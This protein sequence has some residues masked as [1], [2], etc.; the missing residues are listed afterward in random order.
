MMNEA[1]NSHTTQE[2]QGNGSKAKPAAKKASKKKEQDKKPDEMKYV[3]YFY[4]PQIVNKLWKQDLQEG[5]VESEVRKN[6]LFVAAA[7][8]YSYAIVENKGKVNEVYSWGMGECYVL[9]NRS[10]DTEFFPYLL[11]PRNDQDK[12][13]D[14]KQVVEMHCGTMHCTA[15]TVASPQDSLPSLSFIQPIRDVSNAPLNHT[16][17]PV[18]A[19]KKPDEEVKVI[20]EPQ[21][22]EESAIPAPMPEA[23]MEAPTPLPPVETSM[24]IE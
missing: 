23:I 16:I 2:V 8:H 22:V 13:F 4:R 21:P 15:L 11:K 7:G 14:G 6:A 17:P 10:D 19:S 24:V 12:L 9:G 3:E 1:E 18:V 20:K 5:D